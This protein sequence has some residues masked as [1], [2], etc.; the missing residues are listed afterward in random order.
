MVNRFIAN[1]K[2]MIADG[3]KNGGRVMPIRQLLEPPLLLL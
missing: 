1:G 3:K 2:R